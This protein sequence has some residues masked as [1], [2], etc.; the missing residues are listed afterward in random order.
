MSYGTLRY[1]TVPYGTLRYPTVPY[2]TL[3]YPTV[4]YGTLRYP[5]VPPVLVWILGVAMYDSKTKKTTIPLFL[6]LPTILAALTLE[7]VNVHHQH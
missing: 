3:R 5:T 1:P 7:K 4:P 6:R 2:G